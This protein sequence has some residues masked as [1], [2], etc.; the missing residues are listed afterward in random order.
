MTVDFTNLKRQYANIEKEIS[1]AIRG[2]FDRASF[3]LGSEGESFEREFAEYCGVKYCRGVASGTDALHLALRA[4]DIREGDEVLLPVNT[5][6]AT[7]LAVSHVGAKPVFIDV[8]ERTFAINPKKIEERITPRT[9]AIIAVH[10][11][12]QAAEM[13]KILNIAKSRNLKVIEDA[14]QA[15]G[16]KYQDKKTGTLGDVACFSFYPTKNLG[17]YGDGGAVVTNSSEIAGRISSLR[18]YGQTKRYYF[19]E[20]GYNSRLDEIQAAILRV[21]LKY[22]DWSIVERRKT[23]VLYSQKLKDLPIELPMEAA[24]NYHTY[25]LYVIKTE[26]RDALADYLRKK[27]VFTLIHYPIPLHL[28]DA[29]KF[30]GYRKGDFPISE[31]QAEEILSLPMFAEIREDEIEYAAENIRNFFKK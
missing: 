25:H 9:K 12:G 30:L 10:L 31:R 5:F 2:V 3:I 14:C 1:E 18:N 29:Y 28:Q 21:K 26:N 17:C 22:L 13:D 4:L 11:Y 6:F 8:D 19:N 23:A 15:H 7:A 24:G 16:A 27:R 20:L